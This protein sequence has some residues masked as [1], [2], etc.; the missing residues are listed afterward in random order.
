VTSAR[1][2]ARSFW[3]GRRV[4]L[5][6]HTG[7]KGSWLAFWLARMG[8]H[9]HAYALAPETEPSAFASLGVA[10]RVRSV[11]GDVRDRG[12]LAA[13]MREADP[14]IVFHLAAQPLVF[15][16]YR[17]PIATFDVNLMGT[18]NLLDAVRET[19]S[20]RSAVIV[21]TDKVYAE[22]HSGRAYVEDD[23]LGG[24]EPYG[25]SKA[26]A[27]IA[28]AAYRE[29]F[30]RASGVAVA[31]ARAGN[32]VGGGDWSPDRLIPDLVAALQGGT[33]LTLRHPEATRPW[34]HVL[35]PLTGYLILAEQLHR[36]PLPTA[37]AWNFGPSLASVE[38][39]GTVAALFESAW[40]RKVDRTVVPSALREAPK[41]ALD[42][43][44]AQRVLG[45][46]PRL[47]LRETL[48]WTVEWYR[49][50]EARSPGD[51]LAAAQLDRYRELMALTA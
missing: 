45:W 31:T 44:A 3:Q 35:D 50:Y 21:T 14:E 20:V 5:T 4:F 24:I 42:A 7:F 48:Q 34:Q 51:E 38:T 32:V 2:P 22:D 39:V 41:L 1:L 10:A 43:G 29:S 46:V 23:P 26:C 12:A 6:G 17:E 25:A 49:G 30:L 11:F 13:A 28:T 9:V 16:G 37:R 27:E 33:T 18:V 36:D 47:D 15:R 19:P 8:A 40:G